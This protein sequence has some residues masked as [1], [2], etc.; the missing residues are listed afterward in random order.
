M[1]FKAQRYYSANQFP[2]PN[3]NTENPDSTDQSS[4]IADTSANPPSFT[5]PPAAQRLPAWRLWV[6]LLLQIGLIDEA[7]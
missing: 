2:I 5:L 1:P 3:M 6:P 4:E 7:I